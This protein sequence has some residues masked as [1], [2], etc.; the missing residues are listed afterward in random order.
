[1]KDR[2][3]GLKGISEET[4]QSQ[5]LNC[6]DKETEAQ[7]RCVPKPVTQNQV[8]SHRHSGASD[9]SRPSG[10]TAREDSGKEPQRNFLV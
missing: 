5:S 4:S 2:I 1:M 8:S 3:R 9:G 6:T 7:G 10:H